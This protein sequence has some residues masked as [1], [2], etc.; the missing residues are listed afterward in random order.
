[1]RDER[2]APLPISDIM[3][4]ATWLK[5]LMMLEEQRCRQRQQWGDQ[6]MAGYA[7]AAACCCC[8]C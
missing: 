6:V 3:S 8:I 5:V 4:S 2:S 7:N 1:M